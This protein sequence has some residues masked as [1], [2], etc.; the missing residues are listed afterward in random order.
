L[1]FA[2]FDAMMADLEPWLAL[3]KKLM[4]V[5]ESSALQA[6]EAFG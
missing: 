1:N 6:M 4:D 5:V 3:R 2:E